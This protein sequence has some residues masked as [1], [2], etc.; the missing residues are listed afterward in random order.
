MKTTYSYYDLINKPWI[1][2][3]FIYLYTIFLCIIF[4]HIFS[5]GQKKLSCIVICCSVLQLFIIIIGF[6]HRCTV[7]S[8]TL[9]C[10]ICKL[11]GCFISWNDAG[12]K[13][14]L[15][16]SWFLFG[17]LLENY[18]MWSVKCEDREWH[19]LYFWK[20]RENDNWR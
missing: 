11:N 16:Q 6:F 4:S 18:F 5:K 7:H 12:L 17:T 13:P 15:L 9:F 3:T 19:W 1:K 14:S 2:L 10:K 8:S 20:L